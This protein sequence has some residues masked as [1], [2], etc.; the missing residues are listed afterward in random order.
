MKSLDPPD[1]HYLSAALG[2]LGLGNWQEANEEFEKIA[3][4]LRAH[5]DVLEVR[6]QIYA[7]A[8]KWD[9]AAQIAAT[10]VDMQP[11]E[12]GAWISLAYATRRKPAGGLLQAK[13]ILTAMEK[14][15][16]KVWLFPYNLACYCAQL[17]LLDECQR[18]FKKAVAIDEQTVQRAATDDPDLKPLR[19]IMGGTPW[20]QT[21]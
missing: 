3:P 12:P 7:K 19:D 21:D 11:S 9:L 8:G 10:L 1:S 20:K 14:R 16:P 13:A 6:W 17:G 5:P 4:E 18:W 15:F 2:W